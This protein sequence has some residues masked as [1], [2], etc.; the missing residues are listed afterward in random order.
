M[1]KYDHP[2][3]RPVTRALIAAFGHQTLGNKRNPFDELLFIILS[4]KTPPE[5]YQ[6]TYSALKDKFPSANQLARVR[7]KVIAHV[8]EFGGLADKKARQISTVAK[9]LVKAFGRVTLRPLARMDD[10]QAEEFLDTLPGVGKKTARCV[11]MYSLD[12]PVFPVD[13][14]CFRISQRL[15]W[16]PKDHSLT[17]R[18]ADELQAEIPPDLRRDLHVGMVLLGREYC[19]PQNLRCSECP[20]LEYCPTGQERYP[21]YFKW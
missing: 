4:S 17:D 7:P 3:V 12:R 8:I 16:V 10:Q 1:K 18:V 5:R 19:Q 20:L 21:K 2:N 15:G 11:L 13:A 14:H 9:V 6:L